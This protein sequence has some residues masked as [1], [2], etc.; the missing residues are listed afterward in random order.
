VQKLAPGIASDPLAS[1]LSE[2]A[3]WYDKCPSGS[4]TLELPLAWSRMPKP[5]PPRTPDPMA[6]VVDR[7]LAQ[8]PGLQ[9]QPAEIRAPVYRTGAPTMVV[10]SASGNSSGSQTNVIGMWVRV[11]LGLSLAVTMEWWPYSKQCGLP[12]FGYLGAVLI[13]LLAGTWAAVASWRNRSALAHVISLTLIFYGLLLTG[14]ELLPRTG[15][16]VQHATWSCDEV[17]S[18]PSMVLGRNTSAE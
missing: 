14:S 17:G 1:R 16:A 10:G 5:P 2:P 7:L 13:V 9:G 11:L 15:Y 18:L 4:Y 3:G 6:G 12:L 8:L